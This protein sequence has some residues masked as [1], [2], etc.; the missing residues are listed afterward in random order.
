[1]NLFAEVVEVLNYVK[2]EG[3]SL[4]NRNQA[5]GI[6]SYFKTLDFVFLLHLMLEILG[7]TDTLSKH[8]QKKDQDIL[9]AASLV[10]GT[11]KALIVFRKDGFP[12]IWKKVCAF[13]EKHSI[14]I[15]DMSEYYGT[16]RKRRTNT[17][18]QH[19]F[20]VVTFNMVLD[21]QIQEFGD[22]F[23]EVSTKLIENMATLSPCD[24]FYSFD[25]SKL[26]K[27]SEIYKNDFDDSERVHLN[28]Q[29]DIYYHSLLHD[30]KFVN[31]KGIADLSRLLV[32]TGKH[33]SFP[34]VYRLLKLTL[35]LPVATATVERCFFCN[36]VVED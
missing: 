4:S 27:L 29:L 24:S 22:R 15:V 20:E 26:L 23:S 5:K 34:L 19:H 8:L 2:D 28:G 36:E 1:M 13:R 32:E 16:P 31:L 14:G 7:L 11:T 12:Q 25:K 35:V 21:M 6:W 18:N 9:E 17:T 33:L 30:E 10:K 3:S